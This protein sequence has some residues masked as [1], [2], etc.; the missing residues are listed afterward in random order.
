AGRPL[1]RRA[2][3][4]RALGARGRD[5]R[6][7]PGG[8]LRDV[9]TG[10][11]CGCLHRQQRD[12]DTEEGGALSAE[13]ERVRTWA[14][15]LLAALRHG[16]FRRREHVDTDDWW[17]CAGV[18]SGGLRG[19]EGGV[20]RRT[21]RR[22]EQPEEVPGRGGEVGGAGEEGRRPPGA[23]RHPQSVKGPADRGEGS[24]R[25]QEQAVRGA[26]G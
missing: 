5:T 15:A 10:P 17:S 14:L 18:T 12:R 16:S 1:P 26:G 4:R 7:P 8:P 6:T 21:A 9:P 19:L 22:C 24:A 23:E 3:A 2:H 13:S 11:G 25:G 20:C